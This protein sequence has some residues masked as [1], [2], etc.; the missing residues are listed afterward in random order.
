MPHSGVAGR[1]APCSSG[2]GDDGPLFGVAG[3]TIPLPVRGS[4]SESVTVSVTESGSEAVSVAVSDADVGR[5]C[6]TRG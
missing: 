4:V 3:E 2:S 6:L 5:R 1:N